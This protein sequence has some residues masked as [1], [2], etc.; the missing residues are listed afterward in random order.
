MFNHVCIKTLIVLLFF[1]FR[2]KDENKLLK[3]CCYVHFLQAT[4]FING[5][6]SLITAEYL[7]GLDFTN[8]FWKSEHCAG[9]MFNH[10]GMKT[11]IVLLF[12]GFA[13]GKKSN[14]LKAA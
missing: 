11:L 1:G 3:G 4:F 14:C 13:G 6:K 9:I 5:L 2:G 12:F 8:T 7:S 10:V